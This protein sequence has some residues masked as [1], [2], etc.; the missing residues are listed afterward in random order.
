MVVNIM[1]FFR[2]ILRSGRTPLDP[3]GQFG[4]HF[5][6]MSVNAVC[7]KQRR[8]EPGYGSIIWVRSDEKSLSGKSR[9]AQGACH[10][11]SAKAPTLTGDGRRHQNF[12]PLMPLFLDKSRSRST[13]N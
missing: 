6:L 4:A 5:W 9:T 12:Y 2:F 13:S 7:H 3:S 8:L 1:I 11:H 10:L